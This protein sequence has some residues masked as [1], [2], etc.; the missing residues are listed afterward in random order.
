MDIREVRPL[1]ED[2]ER[3]IQE[4]MAESGIDRFA[5][6]AALALLP[7]E[8]YGDGGDL[9]C[10]RPLTDDER[11]LLGLDLEPAE[12]GSREQAAET[13]DEGGTRTIDTQDELGG[14]AVLSA[15]R[16]AREPGRP[17]ERAAAQGSRGSDR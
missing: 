11:R 4:L 2:Q 6:L 14:D 13:R 10:I 12:T 9:Y 7:G 8:I 1:T 15:G 17:R 16:P 3:E 5:A